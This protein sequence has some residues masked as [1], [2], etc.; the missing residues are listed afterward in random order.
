M[1]LLLL[2]SRNEFHMTELI[3]YC[4]LQLRQMQKE[5]SVDE[6]VKDR[7]FKVSLPVFYNTNIY[8]LS[9]FLNL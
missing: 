9:S 3:F 5:L 7:S 6:I 1:P 2:Y 8:N 4:L